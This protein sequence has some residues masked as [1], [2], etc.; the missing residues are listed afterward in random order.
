MG[1]IIGRGSF[2]FT[3]KAVDTMHDSEVR[4][5]WQALMT[6][7]NAE[8]CSGRIMGIGGPTQ[9]DA[10]MCC[11]LHLRQAAFENGGSGLWVLC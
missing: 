8:V 2:G 6:F 7:E 5:H 11:M 4:N 3:Y 10:Q 9:A 1:S